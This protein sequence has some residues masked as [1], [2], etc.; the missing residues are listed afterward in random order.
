MRLAE[1]RWY[2]VTG[3]GFGVRDSGWIRRH[4]P[5]DGSVALTEVTSAFAV[6]NLQGPRSRA[7]LERIVDADLSNAAFPYMSMRELRLGYAPVRAARVT[8][9]GE[10][11]WELHVPTEYGAYLYELL[12]EAG[13]GLG[14]VDAGYKA[15]ESLRLEKRYLYWGADIGPDEN[16]Y[17]AGLGF[18]VKLDKGD[19]IG[20][21]A[22]QRAR[23]E[24]PHRR[25]CCFLLEDGPS[26]HGAEAILYDGKP[27]GITTSAGWGHT[28]QKWIAYG[29]VQAALT[30]ADAFEIEAFCE[31]RPAR[32][33]DG[34][35]YDPGRLKILG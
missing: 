2:V 16:P 15:I 11:G 24:G 21:A 4:M 9:V 31:R 29:Y 26:L 10:L 7:I 30:K 19:F 12:H 17:E 34:A 22:L 13:A 25:L 20:R 1:E 6:L 18:A 8:Y 5:K 3:S 14:L 32:R 35:P 28:V 33:L 27:V 23:T